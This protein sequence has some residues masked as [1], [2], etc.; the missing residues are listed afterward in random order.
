[1]KARTQNFIR[2]QSFPGKSFAKQCSYLQQRAVGL[3]G[4]LSSHATK[5][6]GACVYEWALGDGMLPPDLKKQSF[7]SPFPSISSHPHPCLGSLQDKA[8]RQMGQQ[9][10]KSIK[11]QPVSV[12]YSVQDKDFPLEVGA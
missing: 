12:Q 7:Q 1:M 10:L 3:E 11:L 8:K 9:D 6:K 5:R 4:R 2:M